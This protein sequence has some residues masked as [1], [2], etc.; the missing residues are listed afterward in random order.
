VSDLAPTL[1]AFFIDRLDKQRAASPH[2]LAAYRDT[3]RMLLTFC[4]GRTGRTPSELGFDDLDA[5][6]VAAFLEHAESARGNSVRTRNARLAA[7]HSFF[8][9]AALYHPEHAALIQRVLAMPHKRHERALV[10]FLERPEL[11]AIL[12]MPDQATQIGRRDHALLVLAAQTGLRQSELTGL[13]CRDVQLGPSSYVRCHGKGRK[14]RCTRLTRQTVRVLQAWLAERRGAPGDLLFPSRHG[15]RL[16]PDAFGRLLHNYA[17]AAARQQP[18]LAEKT[19]T[20]HVLRHTCAMELL[21]RGVDTSVIALWLGHEGVQTTQIYLHADMA[22][23]EHALG[24]TTQPKTKTSRYQASD[25][26]LSFLAAR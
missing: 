26:L 10:T 4:H 11:E 13:R 20:P 17:A 5:E 2:T 18:S 21:K 7:I 19:V 6:L 15:G 1:Q 14:E 16:S 24:L 8:Q 23:K 3:F 12:A 25:A 9:Y 22:L